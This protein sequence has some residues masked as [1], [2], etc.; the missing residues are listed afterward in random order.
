MV[1]VGVEFRAAVFGRDGGA[2]PNWLMLCRFRG[3]E[4]RRASALPLGVGTV[5]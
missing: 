3:L 4:S 1:V 5:F 2:V